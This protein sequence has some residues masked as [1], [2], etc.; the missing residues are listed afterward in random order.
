MNK[1][2]IELRDAI[3]YQIEYH[4]KWKRLLDWNFVGGKVDFGEFSNE[5]P[6]YNI[7]GMIERLQWQLAR[8]QDNDSEENMLQLWAAFYYLLENGT[9]WGW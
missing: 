5:Y 1:H 3:R 7:G 9:D 4:E 8:I 6:D 2:Q